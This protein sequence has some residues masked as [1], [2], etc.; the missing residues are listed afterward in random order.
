MNT[1]F[2][3]DLHIHHTNIIKLRGF[4]TNEEYHNLL[5][6]NWNDKV[7]KNDLVYILGDV[8][9]KSKDTNAYNILTQLN[10]RKRVVK[11]NHD[12]RHDLKYMKAN[13]I[14]EHFSDSEGVT[15]DGKYVWL[16]H[17]PHRS[18]NRSYHGSIMLYGHVHNTLGDY[19]LSTDVGVDK[20]NYIPVSFEE[21]LEYFEEELKNFKKGDML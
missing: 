1:F 11:G 12:R 14:I 17:Y 2:T 18:W 9:W 15:I 6:S 7:S 4:D 3:A 5:I 16:S 21:I 20:W 8:V 10:G 13:G 19:G